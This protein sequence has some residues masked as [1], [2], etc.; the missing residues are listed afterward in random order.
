MQYSVIKNR[1]AIVI[2]CHTG[3]YGVMRALYYKNFYIIALAHD[4]ND[5]GMVSDFVSERHWI[6]HPL[7]E[8]KKFLDFLW[9][10]RY[11][12]RDSLIYENDDNAA[13][14]LSKNKSRLSKYYFIQ[15]AEWP[16]LSQFIEKSR[17]H[18]LAK[19]CNVPHPKSFVPKSLNDVQKHKN[20]TFYP[21]I[22]KP[23]KGHEFVNR[24]HTKNFK[25]YDEQTLLEKL[26]QCQQYNLEVM[27]QEIIPGRDD[28]ILKSMGYV[29]KNGQMT[30][31]FFYKKLRQHPPQF[32]V[33]RVG[34]SQP[35]NSEVEDLS[36]RLLYESNFRGIFTVEF[37]KDP[38]DN[39]L[40]LMEVNVRM[41]RMN[42]LATYSGINFP[43]L[44]YKDLVLKKNVDFTHY[45][46]NMY[47]IELM[48]D[49]MNSIFNHNKESY[50]LG[51]YLR[52]YQT[53]RKT[54]AVLNTED[55]SPFLKYMWIIP[56]KIKRNI[57]GLLK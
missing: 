8:E 21:C 7:L 9:N 35:V 56:D 38:R 14:V 40:K 34:Q 24:F 49:L 12:W 45:N 39:L 5:V 57:I 30:K 20:D 53:K 31:L 37:R 29:Q 22:L 17:A 3:G 11:K 48:T 54:F 32:G 51:E 33:M 27:V 13:V 52:P 47:W 15:T 23:V 43:W 26:E 1:K 18:K 28:T 25:V 4:K 16:V 2:G 36:K 41:P 19:K 10:K 6:P 46:P 44:M 50:Q 55:I 42:W